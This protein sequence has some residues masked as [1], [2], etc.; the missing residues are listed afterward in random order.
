MSNAVTS[1]GHNLIGETDGSTGWVGSDLTGTVAKPL[2]PKLGAL[3]NNGGVT[4]TMALLTGSLA[5]DAGSNDLIPAGTNTDQRGTGYARIT[6]TVVDIGAY[7]FG[8]APITT[9]PIVTL[10]TPSNGSST[11]NSEP[12]FS[13]EAGTESGDSSTV[14]IKIYSGNSATGTPVQTLTAIASGGSYSVTPTTPL[15]DGVYT[16][17]ASQSNSDGKTGF[18]SSDT[19]TVATVKSTKVTVVDA[20]G[21]FDGAPFAASGTVTGSDGADLG[22]PT[23]KYYLASDT[24]FGNPL[25]GAPSTVGR[26]T[27]SSPAT[28]VTAAIPRARIRRAS[29]SRPPRRR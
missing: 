7:E 22:S 1:L 5:I 20:G 13:G 29:R 9:T 15:L 28:A 26:A 16:A 17:V 21:T 4:Q 23:F 3:A 2:A 6:G 10:T 19:F 8:S 11:S 12:T 27:P 24:A 18:S 25:G 14:T